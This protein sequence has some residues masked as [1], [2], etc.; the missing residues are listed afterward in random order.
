[1]VAT[2]E[3]EAPQN[4]PQTRP[5]DDETLLLEEAGRSWKKENRRII[6]LI[7]GVAA[8]MLVA[9]ETPLKAWIT[10]IQAWKQYIREVGWLA[11]LGFAAASA[12]AVMLGVPRLPLCAAAGL[13]FG[14]AE[15]LLLSLLGTLTGSYGAF[16][17]ARLSGRRAVQR[18]ATALPLLKTLLARPSLT[19]VFWVRQLMLPGVL[20]NVMLGVSDVGHRVFVLG[21]ALG[22]L[23]MNAAFSLVGSGLGKGAITQTLVQMCGAAAVMNIA[24][25]AMWRRMKNK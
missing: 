6:G 25:W 23:P 12:C 9:H 4:Q 17:F 16:V 14:F 8:F 20:L 10:N 22:Y 7:V 24:G 3:P 18:R 5:P 11:H 2:M 13:L 19:R 1:M 21:T 15:G